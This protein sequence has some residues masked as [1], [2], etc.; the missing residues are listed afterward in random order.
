MAMTRLSRKPI[1]RKSERD[2]VKA[3]SLTIGDATLTE[4]AT[5]HSVASGVCTDD[6][7]GSTVDKL[8]LFL[9][10][11]ARKSSPDG[12]RNCSCVPASTQAGAGG[13]LHQDDIFFLR[14]SVA[15]PRNSFP[16]SES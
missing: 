11:L 4:L 8:I 3:L 12:R 6:L 16:P 14:E 2:R 1:V 10:W 5:T 9:S 15:R 7:A 13:V